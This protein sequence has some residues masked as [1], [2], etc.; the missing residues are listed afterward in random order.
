MIRVPN[1]AEG[2]VLSFVRQHEADANS[3]AAASGVFAVFNLSAD[4]CLVSFAHG[5][6]LGSYA[7]AFTNEPVEIDTT[8]EIRLDPWDYRLYTR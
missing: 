8:T 7:D 5:P 2:H 4:P 1:T 6:Q 3:G